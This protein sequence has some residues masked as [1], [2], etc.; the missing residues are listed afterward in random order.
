M[1]SHDSR[2]F[3]FFRSTQT[4]VLQLSLRIIF[5]RRYPQQDGGADDVDKSPIEEVSML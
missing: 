3:L 5:R 4:D 2:L 1:C